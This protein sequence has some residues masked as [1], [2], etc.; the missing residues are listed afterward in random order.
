MHSYDVNYGPDNVPV[1]AVMAFPM[2]VDPPGW[3]LCYGQAVSRTQKPTDRLFGKI[4]VTYGTGDG[5]TTFNLPDLRGRVIAGTDSMGNV[6]A[7]RITTFDGDVIGNTGGAESVSVTSGSDLTGG[8]GNPYVISVTAG[9]SL[10]PTM[11]MNYY[12][13]L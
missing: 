12:I 3:L 1:G 10:Q 4:G 6:S 8:G 13:K 5:S 2:S 9:A 7:N 11:M